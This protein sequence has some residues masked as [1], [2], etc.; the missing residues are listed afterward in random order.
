M[1]RQGDVLLMPV[2]EPPAEA[3]ATDAVGIRIVGERAGHAHELLGTVRVHGER[4]YVRGGAVLT[5]PEHAHIQTDP[6]WYEVR[7]QREH[8]PLSAAT[9]RW[10]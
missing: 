4:Q 1:I 10:D 3:V 5:H 9:R 7:Q 2:G 8:V 6:V